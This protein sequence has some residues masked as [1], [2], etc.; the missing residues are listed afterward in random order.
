MTIHPAR[1]IHF[2]DLVTGLRDARDAKLVSEQHDG[3][4]RLYCYTQKCVYDRAWSNITLLARGLILDEA[5]EVI[6]ATPFP[7]FFNVGERD[8][9]IPDLP[10]DAIEK[11]DGSLI[12]IW[13][14]GA[15]WRCA[16]KGSFRSQQA[17]A[18][19]M[20]LTGIDLSCL[21]P[22][23]TYLAEYIG[24]ANRIVIPYEHEELVLLAAYDDGGDELDYPDLQ[25]L[26]E[27]LR[28]RVARRH[29]FSS[30]SDLIAHA[31][32]LPAT[33]EGFVLRFIGGFRLKVKGDEYRRIHALIS[34]CTPLAMWEAMQ[35][36]DDLAAIRQKLPE[37]F[38]ADFDGIT[39]RLG[40]MVEG[41]IGEVKELAEPIAHWSDKEVGLALSQW[42][43]PTRSFIFPYRKNSGD[44]LSGK[45]RQA[46]FRA[47]RPTGNYL[48]GYVPSYAMN[49][50][51]DES[52]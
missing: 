43:E 18:A 19:A 16:T 52:L 28:W 33:E 39:S 34:H 17:S 4:L 48:N 37:E 35:A 9:P 49:R 11:L 27:A 8:Q 20:L 29:Q 14:D 23:T 45:T 22:G 26:A 10:F 2:R 21:R 3:D 15:A 50:I 46:L 24:P 36:G 41:I 5:R 31:A 40:A 42:P 47:I 30:V 6:V 44:L 51:V 25:A 1:A 12:I 7:K 13:H 38:W 32:L